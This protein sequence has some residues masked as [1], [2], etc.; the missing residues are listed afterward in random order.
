M[1]YQYINHPKQTIVFL[2]KDVTPQRG[3]THCQKDVAEFLAWQIEHELDSVTQKV[4]VDHCSAE[5]VLLLVQDAVHRFRR[6]TSNPEELLTLEFEILNKRIQVVQRSNNHNEKRRETMS[7]GTKGR[8]IYLQTLEMERNKVIDQLKLSSRS[9]S[10]EAAST[11]S[12]DGSAAS[13]RI[14]RQAGGLFFSKETTNLIKDSPNTSHISKYISARSFVKSRNLRGKYRI[15]FPALHRAFLFGTES[16]A[17]SWLESDDGNVELVDFFKRKVAHVAAQAGRVH[18]LSAVLT[19]HSNSLDTPDAFGLTPLTIAVIHGHLDSC[20][21][22]IE[23]GFKRN[24]RDSTGRNLLSIACRRRHLHIVE[25]LINDLKFPPCDNGGRFFCSPI[26][27]AIESGD[28]KICAFLINSGADVRQPFNKK[29]PGDLALEKG[30]TSILQLINQTIA[31]SGGDQVDAVSAH[32]GYQHGP[33]LQYNF[34]DINNLPSQPY[35][36]GHPLYDAA[37]QSPEISLYPP[38]A[39]SAQYMDSE[40]PRYPSD[41]QLAS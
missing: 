13:K 36:H 3:P 32:L 39:A 1:C 30:Q 21:R 6:L 34:G 31:S 29:T 25:Y 23:A 40:Q 27:D 20:K 8:L 16:E 9:T 5:H 15:E 28:W 33:N 24:T 17:R 22:L 7:Q 26:H 38:T 10:P 41:W 12:S 11:P 4:D 37:S 35:F 19:G 2:E 14:M 18:L